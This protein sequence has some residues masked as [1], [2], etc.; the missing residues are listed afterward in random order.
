VVFRAL[1]FQ[2]LVVYIYN[3]LK[4]HKYG[5][6]YQFMKP[7]VLLRDPELIKMVTVKD[8]EHFMDRQPPTDEADFI[9]GKSLFNLKGKQFTARTVPLLPLNSRKCVSKTQWPNWP[10]TKINIHLHST[11]PAQYNTLWLS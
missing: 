6:V 8:F 2:H 5:G 1:S 3:K 4:G 9:F 11:C 10:V 7:G